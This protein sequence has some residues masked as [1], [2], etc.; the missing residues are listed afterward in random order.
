MLSWFLDNHWQQLQQNSAQFQQ[1]GNYKKVLL[2]QSRQI[3]EKRS[4]KKFTYDQ[5]QT[6]REKKSQEVKRGRARARNS[7]N[8]IEMLNFNT[9]V[10]G[11][12]G[13]DRGGNDFVF[14]FSET[15]N[16]VKDRGDV[17]EYGH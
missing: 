15:S 14:D 6:Q 7:S 13:A 4:R 12:E 9:M 3:N 16:M 5:V 17:W 11:Q 2:G 1:L 8:N 10:F